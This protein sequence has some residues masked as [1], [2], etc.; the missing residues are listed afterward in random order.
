MLW[1]RFMAI[2]VV[3]SQRYRFSS[4]GSCN[5]WCVPLKGILQRI[6]DGNYKMPVNRSGTHL[7]FTN[8]YVNQWHTSSKVCAGCH[9]NQLQ[10]LY[11]I[12]QF[13]KH[14]TSLITDVYVMYS[15]AIALFGSMWFSMFI[16]P[17]CFRLGHIIHRLF[18]CTHYRNTLYFRESGYKHKDCY[19]TSSITK[20][21]GVNGTSVTLSHPLCACKASHGCHTL[22]PYWNLGYVTAFFKYINLG[23]SHEYTSLVNDGNWVLLLWRH[24]FKPG[25]CLYLGISVV[26]EW[27]TA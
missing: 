3:R 19:L 6:C 4:V 8:T 1:S 9:G 10:Y 14:T 25:T 18:F 21:C 23:T 24:M 22:K 20:T 5:D 7:V 17:F 11:I 26:S 2:M 15:R 13:D 12:I 27:R 16:W